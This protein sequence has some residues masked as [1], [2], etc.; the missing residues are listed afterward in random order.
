M[1]TVSHFLRQK[2]SALNVNSL[3]LCIDLYR[4]IT[5]MFLCRRVFMISQLQEEERHLPQESPFEQSDH[6]SNE[7]C[8]SA[9]PAEGSFV[10][11]HTRSRPSLL[12][13]MPTLPEEEED[14]PE[15]LDSSS[16][17]PSTVSAHATFFNMLL[18]ISWSI[19]LMLINED[20]SS[21]TSVLCGYWTETELCRE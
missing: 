21:D 11:P 5:Y 13:T 4:C 20:Y 12:P 1:Y 7:S 8:D 3:I 14:S 10:F 6:N 2:G 16:S 15:E 19:W 17:S 9:R 18:S